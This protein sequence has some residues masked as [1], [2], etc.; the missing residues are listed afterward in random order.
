MLRKKQF[1][2]RAEQVRA[3]RNS[4]QAA[5]ALDIQTE[6]DG[7]ARSVPPVMMRG[8]IMTSHPKKAAKKHKRVKRRFDISL[9]SPGVEVRLPA[10]PV[11]N[12]GWRL[13]SLLLTAG[14]LALLYYFW[15]SPTY[16]VQ[17][18]QVEG[19]V[20]L[21]SETINRTLTIYDQPIFMI[22]PRALETQLFNRYQ[23]GLSTVKVHVSFPAKVVVVLS[24]RVPVL[25]WEQ[26]GQ[27][28]KWV[29]S[30]GIA[31][32]LR[33]NI[34]GLVRVKASA[35]PP[36]PRIEDS[37]ILDE[38]LKPLDVIMTPEMVTAILTLQ[39][40]APEDTYLVYDNLHGLGWRTSQDWDV[41]FGLNISDIDVKLTVYKAI[42]ERLQSDSIK[43]ALIS[44]E[45][46]NAPIYRMNR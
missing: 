42:V 33:T 21:D 15:N 3:R 8:E 34:E 9:A 11:L 4:A 30:Q 5:K 31:F 7:W 14:F 10:V 19:A 22:S 26:E 44:V 25:T 2:T 35:A 38:T 16:R 36:A 40:Q 27:E 28:N 32:P 17:A 6:H 41:Y 23:G 18:A 43:P 39:K 45:Q 29:D 46:V 20:W 37:A 13:G 12:L 24:E 1:P